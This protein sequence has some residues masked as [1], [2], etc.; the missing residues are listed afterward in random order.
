MSLVAE[1]HRRGIKGLRRGLYYKGK[2]TEDK[3]G[4][5]IFEKHY[6]DKMLEMLLTRYVPEFGKKQVEVTSKVD[7]DIEGVDLSKLTTKQRDLFRTLL[8]AATT[9]EDEKE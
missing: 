8:E 1:A 5:P 4:N 3:K 9:E 2:P 6:S 7:F